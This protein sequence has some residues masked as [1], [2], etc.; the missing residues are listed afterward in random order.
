MIKD[1]W[2]NY[3]AGVAIV[4]D[5]TARK[6]AEEA[7]RRSEEKYYNLIEH[8]NDAIISINSAG[9]II[10]LNKMAEKMFGYPREE[11]IGKPSYMLVAQEHKESQKKKLRDFAESGISLTTDQT[12]FEGKALRKDGKTFDI[13]FSYYILDIQGESMA[14]AILRDISERKEAEEKL[15]HNQEQLRSLASQL[16]RVEEQERRNI[17]SYLHDHLGQELFAMKLRLEQMKQS[18]PSNHTITSPG[19]CY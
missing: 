9:R 11:M 18:L 7:V 19:E 16:T 8:A 12:I 6:R 2:G 5:I 14:T 4:R 17:A 3:I 15:I 10:S 1:D 13:E